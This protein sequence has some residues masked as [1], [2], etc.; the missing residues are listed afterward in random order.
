MILGLTPRYIDCPHCGC[1]K[2]VP[3]IVSGNTFG[4]LLWSD[5]KM[6]APMMPTLSVVHRCEDCEKFYMLDR[7]IPLGGSR[8]RSSSSSRLSMEDSVEAVKF[9]TEQGVT[10]QTE[11]YL[12]LYLVHSYNDKFYRNNQLQLTKKE[13]RQLKENPPKIY[14][15]R[16]DEK[17]QPTEEEWLMFVDNTKKLIALLTEEGEQTLKAELYREIGDFKSCEEVLSNA[18]ECSKEEMAARDDILELCTLQNKDLFL[19]RQRWR[20]KSPEL[21]DVNVREMLVDA[22]I[23]DTPNQIKH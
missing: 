12:R 3:N 1:K 13:R 21:T 19:C 17:L 20:G 8:I 4:A 2:K 18:P 6:V 22:G 16:R 7:E 23:D 10:V 5:C 9:F 14:Q 11:I 15:V